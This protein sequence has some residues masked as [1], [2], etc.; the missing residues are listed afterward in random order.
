MKIILRIN[1]KNFHLAENIQSNEMTTS[2]TV[3]PN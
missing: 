3:Q 1:L 2:S